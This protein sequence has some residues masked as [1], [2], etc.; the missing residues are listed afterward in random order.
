[1]QPDWGVVYLYYKVFVIFAM[2]FQFCNGC[3]GYQLI[4]NQLVKTFQ[5]T[6]RNYVRQEVY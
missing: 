1:M 5:E 4:N 2:E 3:M 6:K